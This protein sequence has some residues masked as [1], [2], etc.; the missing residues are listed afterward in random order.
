MSD[1]LRLVEEEYL[2]GYLHAIQ[3]IVMIQ[4]LIYRMRQQQLYTSQSVC[5]VQQR[6]IECV[7]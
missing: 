4:K 5:I 7:V 6:K 2:Q 1:S 3:Q